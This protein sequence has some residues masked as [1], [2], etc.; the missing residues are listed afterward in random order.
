MPGFPRNQGV[1]LREMMVDS[2]GAG[3]SGYGAQSEADTLLEQM[4]M[5]LLRQETDDLF[6]G[7]NLDMLMQGQNRRQSGPIFQNRAPRRTYWHETHPPQAGGGGGG[8]M[9]QGLMG[10]GGQSGGLME[11]LGGFMG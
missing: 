11:M 8:G 2:Y 10:G 7:F 4:L 6:G 9:M 5:G 3:R 1:S